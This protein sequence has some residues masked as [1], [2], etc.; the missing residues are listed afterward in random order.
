MDRLAELVR[1][2]GGSVDLALVCSLINDR[3]VP[4]KALLGEVFPPKRFEDGLALAERW[5][6]AKDAVRVSLEVS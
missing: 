2:G 6:D 1:E 4:T 5:V 3:K